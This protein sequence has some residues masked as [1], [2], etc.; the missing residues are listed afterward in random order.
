MPR[1]ASSIGVLDGE[2]KRLHR[3]TAEKSLRKAAEKAALSGIAIKEYPEVKKNA[4]AHQ[5]FRRVI[6]ILTA[7]GKN[8]AIYEA[9]IN[10]YCSLQGDIDRYVT[11]RERIEN[12]ETLESKELYKLMIDCDRQISKF[13]DRRFAIEKENGMTVASALRTI[14]KKIETAE[15]PLLEALKDEL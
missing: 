14:P 1:P 15:N 10:E 8:D 11:L 2:G 7:V 4:A 5:E 12:D 3:S 6:R 9:V 13:K